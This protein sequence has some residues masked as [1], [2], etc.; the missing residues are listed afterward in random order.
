[1]K[2]AIDNYELGKQQEVNADNFSFVIRDQYR[3]LCPECLESVTMVNGK[4]SK[5]FKHHKKTKSSIECDRRVESQ[6]TKSI[7]ERVGLPL[8]LRKDNDKYMLYV[9]F[10][11]LPDSLLNLT[12]K[13]NACVKII[14]KY[15]NQYQKYYINHQNFSS[16]NIVY[17][18]VEFLDLN[19]LEIQYNSTHSKA[20]QSIWSNYIET[21]ITDRGALFQCGNSGGKIIRVGDCISTYKPYLWVKPKLY[22]ISYSSFN[23]AL[24]FKKIG[25]FT[26]EHR[27]FDVYEGRIEIHSSEKSR[28]ERVARYLQVNL[29]VFLLDS[30]STISAIW[31]PVVRTEN[32]YQSNKPTHM[33]FIIRSNNAIPKVYL[34]NNN[35]ATPYNINVRKIEDSFIGRTYIST[36]DQIINVDR[37]VI[38]NGTYLRAKELNQICECKYSENL[39]VVSETITYSP[40]SITFVTNASTD[41]YFI[42]ISNHISKQKFEDGHITLNIQKKHKYVYIL[43][44]NHL[45]KVF[46]IVNTSY[47]DSLTITQDIINS[48]KSSSN[49]IEVA[50]TPKIVSNI[51]SLVKKDRRLKD[52][53]NLILQKNK[54]PLKIVRILE[55]K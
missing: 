33:Y 17:K 45:I 38:S 9:G 39:N 16:E 8:F 7:P 19:N 43:C 32:G 4:S 6:G 22:N 5:Y 51:K 28:F 40:C 52:I 34:Y 50:L 3:F 47:D 14:K 23:N 44:N 26:I 11:P 2:T 15:S 18:K 46:S 41:V 54:I 20:I 55:G 25:S 31:P 30:E 42:D 24:N 1:M 21:S 10:R 29:K 27:E 35:S 37:R 53:L 48:F 12:E 36:I 49:T 13:E